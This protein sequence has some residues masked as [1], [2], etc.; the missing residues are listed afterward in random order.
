M[1]RAAVA[2]V[3]LLMVLVSSASA[4]VPPVGGAGTIATAAP[5]GEPVALGVDAGVAPADADPPGDPEDDAIEHVILI[6]IDGLRSDAIVTLGDRRTP[7]LNR[8]LREGAAT[9]EA[10]N[11]EEVTI[12]LPNHTSM[13]TGLPASPAL[14]GHGVL[15]N[16]DTGS[17]VDAAAGREVPS[18]FD[19]VH[20]AGGRTGLYAG[21]DKFD[22]LGR[23]WADVLDRY[24]RVDAKTAVRRMLAQL[25]SDPEVVAFVHVGLPDTAGHA[26]GWMSS[27]YLSA[28]E[29]SDALVGQVLGAIESSEA[30]RAD[31]VVVVTSDHGGF[32]LVHDDIDRPEN[33]R[34]PF[35]VWGPGV[36]AG[37]DLYEL[38]PDSR[39]D[40]GSARTGYDGTPPIRNAELANLA[41]D[42]LDLPA[43]P[44]SVFDAEQDL[45]VFGPA[46]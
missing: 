14:G 8:M 25:G 19:V 35:L 34:I 15:G 7:N 5:G 28:V 18:V 39:A 9:L 13:L 30:R 11:L 38:N 33:Y 31:T 40:P 41:L 23:T 6:S 29:K 43:V 1:I 12:T 45:E 4:V 24:Q 20:E 17:T 16:V 46:S 3:G 22:L 32:G 37:A 42:L 26:R 44:G 10:R 2:A 36:P 27:R 21:K